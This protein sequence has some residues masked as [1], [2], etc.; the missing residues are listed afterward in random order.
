MITL[1]KLRERKQLNKVPAKKKAIRTRRKT[2]TKKSSKKKK[3]P[4]KKT[5]AKTSKLEKY[6]KEIPKGVFFKKK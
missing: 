5:T 6:K 1:E 3:A 4:K 2:A